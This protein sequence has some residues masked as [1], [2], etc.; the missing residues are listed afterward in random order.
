MA[1]GGTP[2]YALPYPIQTDSVDVA[3]DVQDLAEALETELLL[4]APLNS[5]ALTGNP[6]ATTQNTSDNSTRIATT[7]FVKSQ[8]YLTTATASSTYAPLASPTFTEVPA[9]PT[10]ALGTNTTQI[11]TTAFAN[12]SVS[13]HSALTTGVHGVSGNVVGTTDTQTLTNK[14]INGSN[15]TFSNIPASAVVGLSTDYVTLNTAQTVSNKSIL[16]GF[17]SP[18]GS[19]TLALGDAGRV[20]ELS[21][22]TLT[23]PH[24]DTVAL[25]IGAQITIVQSTTS[26]ITIA[27]ASG[28]TVS[29][30]GG[31]LKIASQWSAVTLIKRNT[32]LWY[33]FGALVA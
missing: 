6:T 3:G 24:N 7:A 16:V 27:G 13:T 2:I 25:P 4:K 10:A 15:N 21:S 9:A 33:A 14:T 12:S 29:S 17:S 8:S 26:Q 5:P 11:A 32:N 19:Y 20:L 18:S 22:G 31:Y 1:S 23:V 28:V 30:A